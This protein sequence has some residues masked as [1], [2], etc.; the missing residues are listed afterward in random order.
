L[1]ERSA[2]GNLH[3]FSNLDKQIFVPQMNSVSVYSVFLYRYTKNTC[4]VLYIRVTLVEYLMK[5][6]CSARRSMVSV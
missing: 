3:H 6:V 1:N 4:K 5:Y 2:H